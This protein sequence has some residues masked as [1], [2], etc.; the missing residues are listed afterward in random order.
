MLE[1]PF[2]LYKEKPGAT[3]SFCPA[4]R[5][6]FGHPEHPDATDM[7]P[8]GEKLGR[9][10]V[11]GEDEL[12]ALQ[13]CNPL[14]AGFKHFREW[15]EKWRFD[16]ERKH[17]ET[18]GVV[19]KLPVQERERLF[20][21]VL[22]AAFRQGFSLVDPLFGVL[23]ATPA[24]K[25][26]RPGMWLKCRRH[27][28]LD[29]VQRYGKRKIYALPHTLSESFY[30]VLECRRYGK[31]VAV[32]ALCLKENL[33]H[34]LWPGERLVPH[35]GRLVV[36]GPG[37]AYRLHFDWEGNGKHAAWTTDFR[38][39]ACPIVPTK[40]SPHRM[41]RRTPSPRSLAAVGMGHPVV[42]ACIP[43]P[44]DR[45]ASLHFRN[46]KLLR[47]VPREVI[48]ALESEVR[49]KDAQPEVPPCAPTP[50]VSDASVPSR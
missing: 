9:C 38:D 8:C 2:F 48:A 44:A 11:L 42:V 46:R 3:F 26:L 14:L 6:E 25:E 19:V 31:P 35:L 37:G 20:A 33:L 15:H 39:P 27:Q 40:R 43:D 47:R 23:L 34:C 10:A 29:E 50:D 28:I 21:A 1:Y 13:G 18:V 22:D 17:H 12:K 45:Y 4:G 32:R 5:L 36:E 30:V 7:W 16:A 41:V 49:A 24:E